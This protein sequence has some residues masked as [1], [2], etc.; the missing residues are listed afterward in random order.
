[1]AAARGVQLSIT[2]KSDLVTRDVDLLRRIAERSSVQ[3][4]MT[5]TTLDR[6]LA[7]ILEFRAPTPEL[8]LKALRTLR[9]AG[10]AAG[11]T[12]S[13]I[14]PEITDSP[15]NL[16]A[17]IAAAKEHGATHL[18]HNVLFLK[19]SAQQAFF[20]FLEKHFPRLRKRYAAR[21][22][23]FAFLDRA[24]KDRTFR[25]VA[26]LKQKH[27]FDATPDTEPPAQLHEAEAEQ[28]ALLQIAAPASSSPCVGA[29]PRSKPGHEAILGQSRPIGYS[30]RCS[31]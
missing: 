22:A 18:F 24:Y 25:L 15:R 23:R 6:R 17:V 27:G 13:P 14:L 20:P 1:M 19:P 30:Q 7:R 5:V 26:D 21:F 4:N 29:P 28:L 10:I 8:R 3:V 2:T 31:A 9:Q 12:V 11:V 16:D